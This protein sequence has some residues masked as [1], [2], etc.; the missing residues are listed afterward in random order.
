[1]ADVVVTDGF[2]GN[3]YIKGAQGVA[4][5]IQKILEREIKARPMAMV[6]AFLAR[7][8]LKALK[9]KLD[10]R[11]F[12][13]GPLLGVNGVVVVAHG[14]SD[15]YAIRNA[16][17]VANKAAANKIVQAIEQGLNSG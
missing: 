1:M 12:G 6:G 5:I 7:G 16:I 9:A 17:R 13:G 11:E 8:A 10:Y 14:R 15:A 4:L 3:V 2:T